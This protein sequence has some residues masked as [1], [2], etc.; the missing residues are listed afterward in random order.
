MVALK[1]LKKR[2]DYIQQGFSDFLYRGAHFGNKMSHGAL[3]QKYKFV[4]NVNVIPD[5]SFDFLCTLK[6]F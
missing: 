3:D 1:V 6:S 4:Q 2:K 5:A